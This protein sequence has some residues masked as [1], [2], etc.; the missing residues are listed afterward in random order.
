MAE[1]TTEDLRMKQFLLAELGEK[2]REELEQRVLTEAGIRDK[3][4]MAEDDLIEEYLEGSLKG[5]QRERFLRQFLSI[6]HQRHK[7]RTAKSLRR[8]AR[9]EANIDAV[10]VESHVLSEANIDTV[11]MEPRKISEAELHTVPIEPQINTVRIKPERLTRPL[12]LPLHRRLLMYAPIAA[13]VLV[14][15]IV[16]TVWYATYRTNESKRQAIE[17]ELAELN[18]SGKPNLPADQI[19]TL[20]V[21]PMSTTSVVTRISSTFKGP[22]L[23]LWLLPKTKPI[24]RYNALLQKMDSP[25]QVQISTLQLH[26][27][28]GGKA[29]RLRIPTRL[30]TPG[31]YR[32]QL[33]G[34]SS[35]GRVVETDEYSF[36]IE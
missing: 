8:F 22:I 7:L 17:R 24:E 25:N 33:N 5:E 27:R 10:L 12:V 9:G 34:L 23:E 21:S 15:V 29:I 30:L 18:A 19:S 32:V 14:A 1:V 26:D 31:V 3:L 36:K 20:I 35:D 16:G 11:P 13:V 6:P 2:E 28:A 4:L